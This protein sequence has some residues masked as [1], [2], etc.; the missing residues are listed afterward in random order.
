MAS[1]RA[2]NT[3]LVFTVA[4]QSLYYSDKRAI[5]CQARTLF[6]S[7]FNRTSSRDVLR[8]YGVPFFDSFYVSLGSFFRQIHTADSTDRDIKTACRKWRTCDCN[9]RLF[10][11]RFLLLTFCLNSFL[12]MLEFQPLNAWP[13]CSRESPAKLASPRFFSSYRRYYRPDI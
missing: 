5:K 8:F 13:E 10:L 2:I 6:K 11:P 4:V 7:F 12:G 3:P 9:G 1:D